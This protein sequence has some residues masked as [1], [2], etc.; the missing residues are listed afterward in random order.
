M[1][2]PD[3]LASLVAAERRNPSLAALHA[4]V[5]AGWAF[6]VPLSR[7]VEAA[8]FIALI[9]VT[10]LRLGVAPRCWRSAVCTVPGACLVGW[11]GLVVVAGLLTH[12]PGEWASAIPSRQFLVPLL[13]I[14][15]VH[16]WRLLIAAMAIGA[17]VASAVSLVES[18]AVI[19][20][21]ESLLDHQ[22]RRGSFVLPIALLAS[23]AML[24][25]PGLL[26]R[27]IGAA[28]SLL[29]LASLGTTTQR[30]MLVAAAGGLAALAAM[31]RASKRFRLG[32]V[33]AMAIGLLAIAAVSHWSGAAAARFEALWAS[34]G[35][36]SRI[37]LWKAT[38]EQIREQP[39]I[40]HGLRS[41][42]STMEAARAECP[43]CHPVVGDLLD[44]RRDLVYSHNLEVD[45]LFESG[46][47]GLGLLAL[48]AAW[49]IATAFRRA[50][51]EPVAPLALSFLLATFV[52]GQFDHAL[53]RSIPAAITML[54][55][56]VILI[57]RP[58]QHDFAANGLGVEDDW[59]DRAFGR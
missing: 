39:W 42:R 47:I 17:I 34:G 35:Q 5:A 16:R 14:P 6:F 9:A 53:S 32:I 18:S 57:P 21:G 29:A 23:I 37:D 51:I 55:F 50:S 25:G 48:G 24:A 28:S 26:R 33:A 44:R 19:L 22:F 31:P 46:T 3:L 56:T 12:A 7:S 59:V 20:R 40:G 45:L 11:L 13:L 8:F 30:S 54:L 4:T 41:W 43:D 2:H 52:G 38:F 27:A 36:T 1:T 15:V 58:D 49:G 10:V